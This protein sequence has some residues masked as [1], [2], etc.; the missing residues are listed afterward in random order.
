MSE[1]LDG[2]LHYK[3]GKTDYREMM[4]AKECFEKAIKDGEYEACVYLAAMYNKG[5]VCNHDLNMSIG[6]IEQALKHHL[7]ISNEIEQVARRN[8]GAYYAML[9]KEVYLNNS[10]K[11][12][13][14]LADK[15]IIKAENIWKKL[16]QKLY[17]LKI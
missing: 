10:M 4:L 17:L 12:K 16:I 15:Y 5:Q 2:K 6:L 11:K 1:T 9:S 13:N 7:E 8:L 3:K 14:K